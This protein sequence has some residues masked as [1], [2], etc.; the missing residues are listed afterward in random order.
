MGRQFAGI[1]GARGSLYGCVVCN[2]YLTCS[3]ELTSK[4]FTGSTGPATLFKR[5][6][7]VVYGRCEHRKMT[8][9]W[10]TVRDV[11]CVTCNQKLGWMYE[12][13]V[14]ESQTYKETQ[15][16]IENANFEKIAGAIK[17][18]LGEDRFVLVFQKK[19]DFV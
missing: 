5:A 15:V 4:A 18:P 2:T 17:D 16:I 1:C 11:F 14:S 13:A 9:G 7:N 19:I 8:T 10:H 6:W 12:M 3:K